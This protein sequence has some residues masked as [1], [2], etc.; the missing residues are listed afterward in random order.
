MNTAF[1][2]RAGLQVSSLA[3]VS[4]RVP[5]RELELHCPN[6]SA[7]VVAASASAESAI[8]CPE[9]KAVVVSGNGPSEL[10]QSCL[11][12]CGSILAAI[13]LQTLWEIEALG[14]SL[15]L[16]GIAMRFCPLPL[17]TRPRTEK[18]NLSGHPSHAHS[19]RP[20]VVV[21]GR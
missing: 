21:Q 4:P 13:G 11:I 9:C 12:G 5:P 20:L 15:M 2:P 3:Q 6:C 19:R 16:I 8:V 17:R 14:F 7:R 18:R 10:L 1:T